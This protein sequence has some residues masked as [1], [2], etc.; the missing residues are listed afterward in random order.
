M[1]NVI[2]QDM[3]KDVWVHTRARFII[4]G[5]LV[6][7]IVAGISLFALLPSYLFLIFSTSTSRA[8]APS[9]STG[10]VV[11]DRADLTRSSALLGQLAP[12]VSATSTAGG[13]I[14]RVV[15]LRPIGIY[16]EHITYTAGAPSSLMLVGAADTNTA[17]SLYRT[18][19]LGDPRFIH[20]SVPVGAL[21]GAIGGH[22]SITISGK[23]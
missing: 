4:V 5:S 1:A 12:L 7:M 8:V 23:F 19:L 13:A 21:V 15:A 6:A 9:S 2:P 16:I 10:T 22:F 17:I 14:Q 11:S 20:V 18:A 3:K